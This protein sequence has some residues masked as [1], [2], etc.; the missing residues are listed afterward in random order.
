MKGSIVGTVPG[1]A[2]ALA[3]VLLPA[4]SL[5]HFLR[6]APGAL[7]DPL[8]A[9]ADLF[10]AG[11]VVSGIAWIAASRL[12]GWRLPVRS[13]PPAPA[14]RRDLVLFAGLMAAAVALRLH[15]LG[16]GLWYDEIVTYVKFAP[17][18]WGE[19]VTDYSSQNQHILYTLLAHAS[20]EAFGASAW[21]LRLPAALFGIGSIAALFLLGRRV[22]GVRETLLA[23]GLLTF[24]Y[25]HVWFSQNARGYSGMLFWTVLSS[26]L[27]VRALQETRPALWPAYAAAAALGAYTHL[28]MVFVIAGHFLIWA[29][30][31]V[32]RRLEAWPDRWSGLFL[33]FVPAGLLVLQLYA[34]VLPQLFGGTLHQG[35]KSTVADWKSP[36][37]TLVELVR[38]MDVGALGGVVPVVALFA[39]LGLGLAGYRRDRP[40]VGQLLVIPAAV[41][42]VLTMAMG[43]PLWPRFFFFTAGFGALVAVRAASVLGDA[44][45][46][47]AGRR[48]AGAA[49]GTGLAVAAM[50]LSASSLRYAYLPKQDYRAAREWVEQQRRPADAV[51]T[52]GAAALPFDWLYHVDWTE[53]ND[54]GEIR[55]IVA[56]SDRTWLVYTLPLHLES[57]YPEVM[58]TIRRDFVVERRFFGTLG[59]GVITVCRAREAE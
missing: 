58:E 35:T 49:V 47:T 5:V 4:S 39:V 59:D 38:G 32:S 1:A 34:L 53:T 33:G 56:A 48:P 50:L 15:E 52:V 55:R 57:V 10:R 30:A 8:L 24:S 46:R 54:P 31:L 42:G 16:A 45:A 43:H 20:F 25:H 27:L 22:T 11:L 13:V 29:L 14:S 2:L 12:P 19:I 41:G 51:V 37:W 26:W 17:L 7:L 36:V 3:G 18:S 21:T 9:G 6:P 23:C 44:A 28:T 40:V